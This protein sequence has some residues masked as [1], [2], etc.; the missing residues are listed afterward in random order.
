[1]YLSG[2]LICFALNHPCTIAAPSPHHHRTIT[3]SVNEAMEPGSG[4]GHRED[5]P[6]AKLM[7][8]SAYMCNG[9][10]TVHFLAKVTSPFSPICCAAT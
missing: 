3:S 9:D 5:T 4:K 7:Q 2:V 8:V 1:M 10:D 6:E